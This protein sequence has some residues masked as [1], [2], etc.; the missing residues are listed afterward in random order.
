MRMCMQGRP[1]LK[2]RELG[3]E[4]RLSLEPSTNGDACLQHV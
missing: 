2:R 1:G 3:S 4:A